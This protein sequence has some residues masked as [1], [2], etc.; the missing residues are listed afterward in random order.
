MAD[1]LAK[2]QTAPKNFESL[3]TEIADRYGRLS[4]QL[5]RIAEFALDRPDDLAL[6]TVSSIAQSVDVQPSSVVRFAKAFGYDGFSDMQQLFRQRLI[7]A[8]PSYRERIRSFEGGQE[9]AAKSPAL[10]NDFVEQ[11]TAAL[12]Q[13]RNPAVVER[14]DGALDLLSRAKTVL[15]LAQRRA[16]PVAF[17]LSYALGRLERPCLLL[18]GVGGLLRQQA[19][20]AGPEDVLIAASF[21]PYAPEVVEIVAERRAAGIPVVAITDS[22]LSPIAREASLSF[23]LQEPEDQGFRTLVAPMLL[24]QVLVVGLGH[25]LAGRDPRSS[26]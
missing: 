18:D 3:K 4:G 21:R 2:A 23:E 16:F 17:Y 14:L 10:L 12:A 5:K 25:R 26:Q 11:G 22:A 15:L 7:A 6:A 1:V 8:S 9:Q 24:A 13:L 20:L 19:A